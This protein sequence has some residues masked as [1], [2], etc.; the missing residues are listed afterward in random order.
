MAMHPSDVA[1]QMVGTEELTNILIVDDE[2]ANL[3][4]LES[5]LADP[6]YRIVRALSADQALLALMSQ[7]FAVMVLDIQLPD[8]N[9]IELAQMIKERKR[10]AHLPII[11][12]TAYFDQD[13][14]RLQ[15]YGS[16]AV[17]YLHKPVNPAVLRSK[18]AV[19]A[20]LDRKTRQLQRA[21]LALQAEVEERRR[22][23]E[24]LRELNETLERRV[25]ERTEAFHAVDRRLRAMMSSI[26]DG[27]LLIEDDGR[28]GYVNEQGARLLGRGAAEL[29]GRRSGEVF[30]TE[31]EFEAGFDSARA[32]GQ[33]VSFEAVAPGAPERWLQCHCYPSHDGLSVYFHDI[34]DRRELQWRREQLLAA[35]QAA[36]GAADQ[37][38]RAKEEF[39]AAISHELRTPLAAILGWVNVLTHP[40]VQPAMQQ[41]GI[42]A[43]ARNAQAQ[44]VL[45]DDLLEMS[46]IVAGKQLMNVERVDLNGLVAAAA[47]TARPTAQSRELD[48][49][50]HLAPEAAEVFG[51]SRRL[52]QVVMNL[53]TNA[54]KFTPAGGSVTSS[55]R[56][57]GPVV[58]LSV[59]DTG[60]GIAPEFLPQLFDR[61]TQ[62]DGTASSV[63][64]G[65]GLG[66]S[67]VKNLV[68]LHGGEVTARSGGRGQGS[69]FSVRLPRAGQSNAMGVEAEADGAEPP[70][71]GVRVLMVDDHPDVLEAHARLLAERG[72]EV[73]TAESGEAAIALL[74]E[75]SFDVLLSD[76]GMPGMGGYDLIRH[77]RQQS[78]LGPTDLPAAAVT[79]YVRATDREAALEAGFQ[80]CL[81]KAVSPHLLARAVAELA[82]TR[83]PAEPK[84]PALRVLFVEDNEDLREQIGYLLEEA[85][86]RPE[87]CATAEEA[88][89]MYSPERF[90]LVVTDVS[91][92]QMSGTDLARA[93]LRITPKAW[94][95]FASGYA[96]KSDLSDFGPNV[97]ALLKPFDLPDLQQLLAEIRQQAAE[98]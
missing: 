89:A 46:R 58:E 61:F 28:I 36:R 68:E 18:V 49:V 52:T 83:R 3:L 43:I 85:G 81:P 42:Q 66:L 24:L 69:T 55:T 78:G 10:N 79:A 5:V 56:L 51:D 65:L 11:F 82:L 12:L 75:Q 2:P 6:S 90:D 67:I 63:H 30:G 22:A 73:V 34:T 74:G 45:V 88:L 38:S 26:T 80:R 20:E 87:S 70:I 15:G 72:A 64:G 94:L 54:M 29:T 84:A 37:A 16:G 50:L 93:I 4:V 40:S 19:F 27:L 17:D 41:R 86:M 21:N 76:L 32:K 31:G 7:E 35:E 77:V 60:Q 44:A 47:E 33:A 97:R 48:I 1:E 39:V 53:V 23:E 92:P 59:S 62:A 9:G 95:V 8:M 96:M 91:L 98:G 25:T 71:A 57:D 13:Q 14:H